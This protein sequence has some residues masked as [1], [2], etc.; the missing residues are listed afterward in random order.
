M[1]DWRVPGYAEEAELGR[2]GS[3]RVVAAIERTSGD[4]VAVKY[5]AERLADDETFRAAFRGEAEILARLDVPHVAKVRRYVESADGAAII[6]DLVGGVALRRILAE[7]GPASPRAA[8]SV[9][10]GSLHGLAAAHRAGIVHRDYKPENVMVDQAGSSMLV[11]FGIALRAGTPGHPAGTPGYAA[12]EQWT[13]APASPAG[14]IYAAAVTFTECVT[15]T[16]PPRGY[17]APPEGAGDQ[18]PAGTV[19][20]G[21]LGP[22]LAGLIARATAADPAARPADAG[23]LLV[24]LEEAAEDRYGAGWEEQGRADLARIAAA[25]LGVA[26]GVMAGAAAAGGPSA[27]PSAVPVQGPATSATTV[28]TRPRRLARAGRA[29]HGRVFAI[30]GG[31]AAG[32]VAATGIALAI[33]SHHGPAHAAP[34]GPASTGTSAP[35]TPTASAAA[36]PNATSNLSGTWLGHYGGSYNGTFKLV[37]RQT[38]SHL[39]GTITT[40]NPRR[41]FPINGIVHG[42]SIKFGTVGSNAITYTGTVSGNSMSGTFQVNF[43]AGSGGGPWRATK[44]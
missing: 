16:G 11:D 6:M 34:G 7:I 26:A 24:E 29:G 39:H 13:G 27:V 42:R 10:S 31:I 2:G 32:V 37:W 36:K 17:P 22:R 21:E 19:T 18:S 15:G 30:A 1:T 9:L 14:D 25:M 3:G 5:L 8:L 4:R 44:V 20:N 43:G 23:A 38:G 35:A 40:S 41:T 12:P 28:L 33:T